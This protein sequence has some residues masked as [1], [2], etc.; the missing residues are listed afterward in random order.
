MARKGEHF[1]KHDGMDAEA[2]DEL[3]RASYPDILRYCLWHT[4]NRQDAE[5]AAQETFLKAVRH[6]D[7]YT[8]HGN[9]RAYLYKIAVHTC[10]DLWR[11]QSR[12]EPLEAEHFIEAGFARAE[13]EVDLRQLLDLL[14]EEQREVVLLRYVQEL[15]LREIAGILNEPLRTVQS[16]LRAALKSLKKHIKEGDWEWTSV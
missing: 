7:A 13:S 8:G 11:R 2:L 5:D 3:I 1:K 6:M 4:A 12:A 14:P 10:T 16:R 9:F 15:K